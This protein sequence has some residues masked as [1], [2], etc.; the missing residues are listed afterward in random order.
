MPGFPGML[1]LLDVGE[2]EVLQSVSWGLPGD[3]CDSQLLHL[4]GI[5]TNKK[6]NICVSAQGLNVSAQKP[7]ISIHMCAHMYTYIYTHIYIDTHTHS[8]RVR[9]DK[10]NQRDLDQG[11]K[12]GQIAEGEPPKHSSVEID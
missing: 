7:K 9:T 12:Q 11:T 5:R 1:R 3:W 10:E 8:V 4:E 6:L 2:R